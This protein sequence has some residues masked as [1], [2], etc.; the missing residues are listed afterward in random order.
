[1]EANLSKVN[2]EVRMDRDFNLMTSLLRNGE[3]TVKIVRKTQPRT[4]SQNALMWMWYKCMEESTGQAKEDFHD[5][6]KA[7]FLQRQI[8]IGRRMVTVI[9]STAD[10]NTM[11]MTAYLEKVKADA[12]TE[13]GISLPL[14]EDRNYQTFVSEYRIR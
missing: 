2:G 10:L 5:Y 9:G 8:M 11:Q 14:P 6:Y 4:I 13:F 12:A 7:K 1:M 3:Y